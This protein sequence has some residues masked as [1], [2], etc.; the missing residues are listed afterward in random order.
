[1]NHLRIGTSILL[2]LLITFSASAKDLINLE[3]FPDW[4]KDSMARESEL[5][6]S[7]IIEIEQYNIN[8]KVKGKFTLEDDSDG[9]HYY[10]IDIG[11]SSPVE[12]YIFTEFD[13]TAN[14]LHLLFENSF[15]SIESMNEKS[16]S[17]KSNYSI[18]SGVIG[19]TPYLSLDILYNLGEGNEKVAG[20]LKG[21]SAQTNS[22]LQICLHNEIGYRQTFFNVFESFIQAVIENEVNPNFFEVLYKVSINDIPMGYIQESY[23]KDADGDVAIINETSLLI[24]VD[25]SSI[26]RTDSLSRSWSRPDGSIIN[27]TEYA[28][29]NSV[30]TSQ[31]SLEYT[32]DAWQV[33]GELQGKAV[34][35]KLEHS[36]SLLSGF[37]SYIELEN[38]RNSESDSGEFYMWAPSADPTSALPVVLRKLSDNENANF[39]ID[40]GAMVMKFLADD[41]GIFRQGTIQQGPVSM[42]MELIYS[43]GTPKLP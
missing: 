37:G 26:A 10:T 25:A 42:K 3:N 14:S 36:S 33:S 28:I 4:F 12:C 39:E 20:V 31:F 22:T 29:E 11:S 8:N 1:M 16:L 32:D 13:G 23:E 30:L 35:K 38:L 34:T 6:E 41:Q 7:S 9:M 27:A 18:D 15:P 21:L 17:G 5:K 19:N 2:S 40:M 43:N 24:P